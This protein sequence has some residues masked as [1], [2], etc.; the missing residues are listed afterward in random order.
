MGKYGSR[1]VKKPSMPKR[2]TVNPY[3]RGI[4][5]LLMLI[6]PVFAYG[7]GDLLAGQG[8]GYP[9]I[10]RAW[11]GPMQFPPF[12]SAFAGLSWVA[13]RLS[14]IPHL[15]ATLAIAFVVLIIVGGILS[16]IFG[17]TYSLLAPP[18]Y[19]PQDVPLPRIRTKKY[20]R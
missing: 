20:K 17:W 1:M 3:M 11:Y 14:S 18:K 13:A 16:V 7:V 19:G 2:N 15:P 5:C 6:V 4:G 12:I 8:F 9:V 10:P